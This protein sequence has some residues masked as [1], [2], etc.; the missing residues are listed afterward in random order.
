MKEKIARKSDSQNLTE[1]RLPTFTQ[2]EKDRIVGEYR[3]FINSFI[4]CLIKKNK[5]K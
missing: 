4:F 3:T 5:N 2:Q 1:S